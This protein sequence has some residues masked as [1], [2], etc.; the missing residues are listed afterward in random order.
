MF[1][2]LT[3]FVLLIFNDLKK[4][5]HDNIKKLKLLLSELPKSNVNDC[6]LGGNRICNKNT[7]ANIDNQISYGN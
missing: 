5:H 7:V 3:Y 1:D 6:H 2:S 4:K